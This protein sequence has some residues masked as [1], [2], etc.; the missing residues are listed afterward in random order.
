M[1]TYSYFPGCSL[2]GTAKEYDR[3]LRLVAGKLGV[4][5]REIEDWTCCGATAAHSTDER[6]SLSLSARN[7]RL[8][9]EAGR[10]L[11]APCAMCFNRMRVAQHELRDPAK[12]HAV[13]AIWALPGVAEGI[14][15]A[16]GPRPGPVES[17]LNVDVQGLIQA[18]GTEEMLAAIGSAVVRPLAG[19]KVVCY[20]GCLS[21]RPPEII[22]PDSLENPQT[23]DRIVAKLG[24][25]VLDWPF[26]TECCG[27]SLFLARA[28]I[29]LAL[30]RRLLAMARS[31][32][33]DGIVTACPICHS[34]LDTRQKQINARF[35][36]AFKLPIYYVTELMGLAFGFS[37][38]ELWLNKHLTA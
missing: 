8:A 1:Q 23:M 18:F 15:P 30:A 3:S 2:H 35:G 21:V 7:L 4:E 29:V 38:K 26:K 33:A 14:E 34:N 9:A 5:L 11:L 20:Y 17:V 25:D 28:D 36:D 13:E 19:L 27:G 16:A 10:P 24:A 22:H 6:L 12:Q 37:A 31:V 32:G